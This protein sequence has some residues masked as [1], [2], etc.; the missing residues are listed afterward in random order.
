MTHFR[1]G[2]LFCP[3]Y[4]NPLD[5]CSRNSFL[6]RFKYIYISRNNPPSK[7]LGIQPK[8][9][10]FEC[11]ENRN[12]YEDTFP[13]AHERFSFDY[14]LQ[15]FFRPELI[16]SCFALFFQVGVPA[17]CYLP[18]VTGPCRAAFRRWY[19]NRMSGRCEMF[20]YGGCR[21]NAN[22]FNTKAECEQ[23][24]R[25]CKC[26]CTNHARIITHNLLMVLSSGS[27][28]PNG[29]RAPGLKT[30]ELGILCSRPGC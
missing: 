25:P 13:Q 30:E 18:K 16:C 10:C 22:N 12:V 15:E 24:C 19:F 27:K 11:P 29:F 20:I 5:W 9:E 23:K 2:E 21:G 17:I 7:S 4:D 1:K 8:L 28:V 6:R 3:Q 26:K 14:S